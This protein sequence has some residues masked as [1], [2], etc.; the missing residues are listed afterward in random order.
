MERKDLTMD[1][2]LFEIDLR[3]SG[4]KRKRKEDLHV[5]WIIMISE[6]ALKKF[7]YFIEE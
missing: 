3:G 2:I 4:A 6:K 7:E 1:D 5:Y